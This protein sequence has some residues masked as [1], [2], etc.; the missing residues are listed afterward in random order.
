MHRGQAP[1]EEFDERRLDGMT[2]RTLRP[3][4]IM[5]HRL[6]SRR[7][8]ESCAGGHCIVAEE[9]VGNGELQGSER[10]PIMPLHHA[11]FDPRYLVA[12]IPYFERHEISRGR[13]VRVNGGDGRPL[14]GTIEITEGTFALVRLGDDK[15]DP[16]E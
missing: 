2:G 16:A 14:I 9:G 6:L 1:I 8:A 3:V 15:G 13:L 7:R 10:C 5:F 12:T 11:G 4:S